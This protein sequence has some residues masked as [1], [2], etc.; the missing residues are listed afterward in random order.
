MAPSE[1]FWLPFCLQ[2]FQ[3]SL[4]LRGAWAAAEKERQELAAKNKATAAK[5]ADMVK[6]CETAEAR[7]EELSKIET[8]LAA[9]YSDKALLEV[10]LKDVGEKLKKKKEQLRSSCAY[11]SW[12]GKVECMEAHAQGESSTWDAVRERADFEEFFEGKPAPLDSGI[13]EEL[14]NMGAG[15]AFAAPDEGVVDSQAAH[16]VEE[17]ATSGGTPEGDEDMTEAP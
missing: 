14:A 3:S 13:E 10:R 1:G 11:Y 6:R 4:Y 15:E 8:E 2:G 16:I 17:V 9:C 5:L 12:L 7:V